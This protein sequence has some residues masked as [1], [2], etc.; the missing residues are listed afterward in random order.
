MSYYILNIK[1]TS[2]S[3]SNFTELLACGFTALYKS[4][5]MIV[6][7]FLCSE[8]NR[9]QVFMELVLTIYL[10][11][12]FAFHTVKYKDQGLCIIRTEL[13][14]SVRKDLGLYILP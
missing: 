9:T 2:Q 14:R 13:E 7:S 1:M 12:E 6:M 11:T 10:S 8:C 4:L 5:A 3:L